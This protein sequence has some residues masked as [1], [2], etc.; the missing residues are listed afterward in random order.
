MTRL[1]WRSKSLRVTVELPSR[2]LEQGSTHKPVIVGVSRDSKRIP[3]FCVPRTLLCRENLG[4]AE[5]VNVDLVKYYLF[6]SFIEGGTTDGVVLRVVNSHTGNHRGDD[7]MLLE[8]I[9]WFLGIIGSRSLSSLEGRPS[10]QRGIAKNIILT[11]TCT[12][13]KNKLSKFLTTYGIPSEYKVMP[14]KSNQTIYDAHDGFVGLYTHCFSLAYLKL[15]IPKFFCD[16]IEYIHVHVSRLNPF[17]CVK[18]STFAVRCKAYNGEPMVELFRG[19]FNL[20]PHGQWLTFAKRPKKDVPNLL[21][22]F[23]TRTE[24]WKGQ[25]FYVKDFIVLG[26]CPELLSKDNSGLHSLLVEMVFTILMILYTTYPLL[27]NDSSTSFIEI[28]FRSFMYAEYDEDLFFLLCDPSPGFG[29]RSPSVSINNEPPLLVAEVVDGVNSKQLVENTTDSEGSLACGGMLVIGTGSVAGRIKVRRCRTSGSINPSVKP[30]EMQ[31]MT[32]CHMMISNVTPP[33][34]RG[35]FENQLDIEPL[36]LHD[37]C[38]AR[39]SVVD[40]AMN[41]RARELLKAMNQMKGECDVLKEWEKARDKDHK[42]LRL[43]QLGHLSFFVPFS[44]SPFMCYGF[45][46][47]EGFASIHLMKCSTSIAKNFKFPKAI[48]LNDEMDP[49]MGNNTWVLADLPLGLG[50]KWIFKRKLKVDESIEKF[51]PRLVI[52]GFRQKSKID[53]FD[54]YAPMTRI[55]TIRLL[56][57]L[58]SIHNLI[59]HQIG[60]KMAFFNGELDEE[61]YMNKPQRFIMPSNENKVCKLIKY[62]FGLKQAPKQWY[63]KFD[64]VV[65]SNCYLLNQADKCVYNKFDESGKGVII[66]LYVDDMLIFGTNQVYVNLT[67]KFLSFRFSMKDMGEVDVIIGIRIKHR[68]NRISISQSYYIENVMKKFNYCDCTP[69]STSMDTSQN[70]VPHNVGKLSRY[71]SNHS[72]STRK[73]FRGIFSCMHLFCSTFNFHAKKLYKIREDIVGNLVQLWVEFIPG[74]EAGGTECNSELNVIHQSDGLSFVL[75]G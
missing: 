17:G 7:F 71:T 29:T 8:T 35:H 24:D 39:Q 62:L 25:F 3:G 30:P 58:A 27:I 1:R 20:Y 10:S 54:T 11:Q 46:S 44:F 72:T 57:T 37:R 36:D 69:V 12:L 59:T 15:P 9:R 18:L 41:R 26:D 61:V 16:V 5:N 65:L 23:I 28:A 73:Q 67:K 40:N 53:Y 51:K 63:Q 6:P 33:A 50:C 49:I 60:V 13:M 52:L 56:I 38:H 22:K 31:A 66:C 48:A 34:W 42:E 55:S 43:F 21:P 45:F 70:L 74:N 68:N 75:S 47:F 4:R 2:M 19:F 14:P 64:E 32:L